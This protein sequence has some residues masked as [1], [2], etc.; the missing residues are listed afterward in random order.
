MNIEW[1]FAIRMISDVLKLNKF[2]F[3][4]SEYHITKNNDSIEIRKSNV[5]TSI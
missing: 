5:P 1:I 4:D 3:I 2:E